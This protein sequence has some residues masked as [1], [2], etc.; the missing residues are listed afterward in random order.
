MAYLNTIL[1][2]DCV[3]ELLVPTSRLSV[4]GR[5]E[6]NFND[7]SELNFLFVISSLILLLNKK[8]LNSSFLCKKFYKQ[9]S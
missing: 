2:I 1:E 4:N 9:K 5:V 6:S 7:N 8:S 3:K